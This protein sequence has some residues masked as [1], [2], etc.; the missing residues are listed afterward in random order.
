M[1]VLRRCSRRRTS[2]DADARVLPVRTLVHHP[3]GATPTD[4]RGP[5]VDPNRP[6]CRA[7]RDGLHREVLFRLDHTQLSPVGVEGE[8]RGYFP[9]REVEGLARFDLLGLL[10]LDLLGRRTER[11]AL[12]KGAAVGGGKDE[13]GAVSC[14]RFSV[15]VQA[16]LALRAN[17]TDFATCDEFSRPDRGVGVRERVLK[18]ALFNVRSRRV[19]RVW[20]LRRHRPLDL[21]HAWSY[22]RLRLPPGYD[23]GRPARLE[24]D[25]DG[26]VSREHELDGL[27]V[28]VVDPDY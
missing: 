13:H 26:T 11:L 2:R 9:H 4:P 21:E 3:R 5:L 10:H 19:G 14:G 1:V 22:Q 24:L 15:D 20:L 7:Y 28:R 25:R 6:L 23:R 12:D 18:A 8:L 16:E 27:A 17:R